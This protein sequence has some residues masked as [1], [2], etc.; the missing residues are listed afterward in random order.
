MTVLGS[1][2]TVVFVIAQYEWPGQRSR[3]AGG[4]L[5]AL[6]LLGALALVSR[7]RAGFPRPPRS[8][9]PLPGWLRWAPAVAR[10]IWVRLSRRGIARPVN[11]ELARMEG[12]V[13]ESLGTANGVHRRL[14]PA[15]RDIVEDQLA[16]TSGLQ[17]GRDSAGIRAL[18]GEETWELTRPDRPFPDDGFAPG[19]SLGE[20]TAIVDKLERLAGIE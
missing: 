18:L 9:R 20:L 11:A 3:L 2:A 19:I 15:V 17:L 8:A 4:W 14:R 6:G 12:V 13:V 7:L 1:I 5:G 16:V 10:A